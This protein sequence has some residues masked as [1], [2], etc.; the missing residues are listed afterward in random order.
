MTNRL[1]EVMLDGKFV[2]RDKIDGSLH[3]Y[4]GMFRPPAPP[5][6]TGGYLV[7]PGCG[8]V[9]QTLENNAAHYQLGH[10]DIPQYM[11]IRNGTEPEIAGSEFQEKIF[12]VSWLAD[13]KIHVN[14]KTIFTALEA[15]FDGE[16]N[17]YAT[18]LIRTTKNT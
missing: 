12:I 3:Q 10:F 17:F 5:G 1:V 2:F 4:V 7:C 9:L 14:R 6:M 11:T 13:S 8:S 18:E 15:Y 16:E